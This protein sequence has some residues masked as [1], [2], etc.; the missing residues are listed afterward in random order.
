M[1]GFGSRGEFLSNALDHEQSANVRWNAIKARG[2]NDFHTLRLGLCV[3]RGDHLFHK[4]RL[5]R[6]ITIVSS[7]S[8]TGSHKQFSVFRKGPNGCKND[9]RLV[10]EDLEIG[11]VG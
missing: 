1:D 9:F 3:V 6:Q 5:A 4:P 2:V 8:H 7:G 10:G 11:G